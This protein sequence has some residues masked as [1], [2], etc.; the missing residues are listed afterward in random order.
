MP[1]QYVI[2]IDSREQTPLEFDAAVPGTLELGDYSIQGQEGEIAIERKSLPDLFSSC[3]S[4]H[5][6]F[7]NELIKSRGLEY[8]AIVIEGTLQQI[9]DKKFPG[10]YNS[11]MPGY[12]IL[13]QL[14]SISVRYRIPIFFA[15]DRREAKR[16]IKEIF[17]AFMRAKEARPIS[18][19]R[20]KQILDTLKLTEKPTL[21]FL[22]RNLSPKMNQTLLKTYILHLEKEA[23]IRC[24][25]RGNKTEI[26]I[27]GGGNSNGKSC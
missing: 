26:E 9:Q 20:I 15:A 4:G 25:N 11:H 22:K 27:I 23:A 3:G 7:K 19:K 17:D 8:F 21:A 24:I 1:E 5:T 6:R 14:F 10:S 12:V 16:I 13:K 18:Q 2:V